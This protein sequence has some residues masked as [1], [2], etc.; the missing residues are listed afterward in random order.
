MSELVSEQVTVWVSGFR[1]NNFYGL[2]INKK[3]QYEIRIEGE[4]QDTP[5]LF[6]VVLGP[7]AQFYPCE[8]SEQKWG[9]TPKYYPKNFGQI[10]TQNDLKNF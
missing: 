9:Q 6:R 1:N 4:G 2:E 3:V 5:R 10:F 7:C 8:A